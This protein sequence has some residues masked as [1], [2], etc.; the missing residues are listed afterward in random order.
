VKTRAMI[1]EMRMQVTITMVTTME[2]MITT[3][4]TMMRRKK[5]K[6]RERTMIRKNLK[7]SKREQRK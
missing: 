3:A 2:R 1:M 7:R 6:Q 5:K 4:K